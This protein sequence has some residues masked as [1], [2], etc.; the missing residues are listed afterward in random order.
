MKKQSFHSFYMQ[1]ASLALLLGGCSGLTAQSTKII[2]SQ[3][4]RD[5]PIPNPAPAANVI[6]T[7]VGGDGGKIERDNVYKGGRGAFVRAVF[8]VGT[9]QG[10]LAPGG[11][12][13]FIVGGSGDSDAN[14]AN[15]DGKGGGG[16]GGT[17]IAYRSPQGKWT[18]LVVAGGGGGGSWT[19]LNTRPE[20]IPGYAY[21]KN[22]PA[23]SDNENRPSDEI[24]ANFS[25]GAGAFYASQKDGYGLYSQ[26]GW[27]GGPDSGEPTGGGAHDKGKLYYFSGGWG[28]GAGGVGS[29]ASSFNAGGGGGYIGG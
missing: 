13:R 29:R 14:M 16:G 8:T 18:L 23:N 17:G 26:A 24:W 27:A 28:F 21:S 15:I 22:L 11:T 12:L 20:G 19:G 6:L 25:D 9:G 7:A 2:F 4:Y 1:I 10:E 5:I 3:T